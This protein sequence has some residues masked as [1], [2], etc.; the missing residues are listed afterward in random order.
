MSKSIERAK[1]DKIFKALEMLPK[2]RDYRILMR[3]TTFQPVGLI[4]KRDFL[5]DSSIG[6]SRDW[7]LG[8]TFDH[9]VFQEP[10]DMI[11]PR[12]HE[13]KSCIIRDNGFFVVTARVSDDPGNDDKNFQW[14]ASPDQMSMYHDLMDQIKMKDGVII[15]QAEALENLTMNKDQYASEANRL[16]SH[17]RNLISQVQGLAAQVSISNTKLVLME[18]QVAKTAEWRTELASMLIESMKSAG[19]RGKLRAQSA[20]E[21]VTDAFEKMADREEKIGDMRSVKGT[22]DNNGMILEKLTKIDDRMTKL[23]NNAP[24]PPPT[25]TAEEEAIS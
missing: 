6:R 3:S 1:I 11:N 8:K 25:K 2:E 4:T 7:A 17:N 22:T 23:E 21:I 14:F 24:S 12:T 10:L 15:D 19:A 13:L 16:G 20:E 18:A 9:Q 5:M